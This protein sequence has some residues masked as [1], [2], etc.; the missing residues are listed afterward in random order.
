MS[1]IDNFHF[2]FTALRGVQAGRAFYTIMCPLKL[3]PRI[4]VFDEEELD[5]Q[6]RAQR[7]INRSRVPEI[8][9]YVLDNP[10]E[11]VFSSLTTSVD[12][13]VQFEPMAASNKDV[14]VLKIPMTAKFLVN[15]GQHRRAA[16]E[17]ALRERPELGEETISIVIFIDAGL[18][19]SQQMFADLNKHAIRPTK[20]LGILY[21]HRDP[22]ADLARNLAE[23]NPVFKGLTELEK[24]S[25]SN[26]SKKLFTLSSIYQATQTL[27][28][29][30]RK[31]DVLPEQEALA[32]EFWTEVG[33]HVADWVLARQGKVSSAELRR[34]YVHAH[35]VALQALAIAGASLLCQFPT[36]WKSRLKKLETVDWSRQNGQAW[37]GRALVA[38]RINKTQNHVSLAANYLKTVL[39]LPLSEDERRLEAQ[40]SRG[41]FGGDQNEAA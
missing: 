14:G 21:D 11:Y 28:A 29:L 17:E 34:D 12:S 4:L 19:R 39:G 38:G 32:H 15:D 10:R 31:A 26:R 6:L 2:S 1:V 5:P 9:R 7:T 8:A 25:I 18:K 27:L 20:S 40:F 24:T 22:I 30:S 3:V 41:G 16:I 23:N 37:E 33:S 35:G 13:R 36:D